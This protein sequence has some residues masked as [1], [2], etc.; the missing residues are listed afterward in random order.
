MREAVFPDSGQYFVA[1]G[2]AY[3]AKNGAS[4]PLNLEH[5]LTRLKQEDAAVPPEHLG[6]CV[7]RQPAG[8]TRAKYQY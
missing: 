8:C 7:A 2:A 3:Y 1:L 4:G 6:D 5:C